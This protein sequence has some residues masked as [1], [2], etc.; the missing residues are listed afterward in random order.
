MSTLAPLLSI[1]SLL[2]AIFAQIFQRVLECSWRFFP[3]FHQIKTFE[4]AASYTSALHP[5]SYTSALQVLKLPSVDNHSQKFQS[6][7]SLRVKVMFF[8]K[9]A[10]N[11]LHGIGGKLVIF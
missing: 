1:Q 5:A 6:L 7:K 11:G 8:A 9:Y 4:G 2:D 3:D 10:P